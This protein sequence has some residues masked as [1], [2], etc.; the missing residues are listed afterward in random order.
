MRR[1]ASVKQPGGSI[2]EEELPSCCA[3]RGPGLPQCRIEVGFGNGQAEAGGSFQA[4]LQAA[5][6]IHH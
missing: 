1:G 6:S 5:L 2:R 3:S 4:A